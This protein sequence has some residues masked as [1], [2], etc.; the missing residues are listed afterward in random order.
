M[1][2]IGDNE[3]LCSE[4][5]LR[6]YKFL[7]LHA[8]PVDYVSY[9][10]DAKSCCIFSNYLNKSATTKNEPQI[11]HLS[12]AKKIRLNCSAQMKFDRLDEVNEESYSPTTPYRGLRIKLES[13]GSDQ[14]LG[15]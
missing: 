11:S 4:A 13:C 14:N 10:K 8:P 5:E 3:S 12:F 6:I 2:D 7:D 9:I 1:Q 15:K